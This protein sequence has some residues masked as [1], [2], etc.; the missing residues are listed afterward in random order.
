M[1]AFTI[2]SSVGTS[3]LFSVAILLARCP[4]AAIE[5][6]PGPTVVDLA[7]FHCVLDGARAERELGFVADGRPE[8]MVEQY[9]AAME[10][11]KLPP[12]PT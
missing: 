4:G 12:T 5:V 8:R 10:T 9:I 11:M 6:G 7:G 2:C 1:I 3:L